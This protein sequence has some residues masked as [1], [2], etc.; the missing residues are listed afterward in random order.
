MNPGE[1]NQTISIE[2][3]TSTT[4][5]GR[6]S[7]SWGAPVTG[8]RAKVEQIDGTRY[9]KEEELIDKALYRIKLWDNAYSD[10]IRITWGAL[11]LTPIR[12]LTRNPG[13]SNMNEVVILAAC[14]K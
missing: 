13:N 6:S 8:I 12:P 4:I 2:T 3:S 5:A 11:I 9:L 1:L 10:N 14:K 7:M